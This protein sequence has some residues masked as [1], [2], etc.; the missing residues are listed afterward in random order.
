MTTTFSDIIV[1][2]TATIASLN[3][4]G[5][6]CNSLT[7]NGLRITNAYVTNITASSFTA[8]NLSA[9]SL[10]VSN[11]TG[12]VTTF[13][14]TNLSA[15]TSG[16]FNG[17][18]VKKGPVGQ[19]GTI[20]IGES[21][22]LTNSTAAGLTGNIAIGNNALATITTHSNN[23]AIGH[24]AI[25]NTT[26]NNNIGINL[27]MAGVAGLNNTIAIGWNSSSDSLSAGDSKVVIG[28]NASSNNSGSY[29]TAV[30]FTSNGGRSHS[31]TTCI[32][33]TANAGNPNQISLGGGLN[34]EVIF[35]Q[36]GLNYNTGEMGSTATISTPAKQFIVIT[37]GSTPITITL[38]SVNNSTVVNFKRGLSSS[39][40]ITFAYA[41]AIIIPKSSITAATS[42]VAYDSTN[43][44]FQ[45]ISD[46]TNW[47]QT[48]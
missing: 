30:G 35:V 45:F 17:I 13:T 36:G 47:Y 31:Y 9:S 23:I 29:T 27:S 8:T 48:I 40:T 32:G 19:T 4:T 12:T 15:S 44:N 22:V 1:N 39:G 18:N 3:F 6:N 7:T 28:V 42:T 2:N 43:F 16:I 10:S 38:P 24:G 20:S 41:S 37:N 11:F 21:N 5:M 33:S 25:A 14:T 34:N 46:G 26:G